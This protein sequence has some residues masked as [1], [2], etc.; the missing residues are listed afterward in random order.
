MPL[1]T[2]TTN[3]TQTHTGLRREHIHIHAN[4]TVIA[5]VSCLD[6]FSR[7]TLSAETLQTI[8]RQVQQ[9]TSTS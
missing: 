9:T 8:S 7:P 3:K 1:I 2:K 4:R 5:L 6:D